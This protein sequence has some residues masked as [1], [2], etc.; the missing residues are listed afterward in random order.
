MIFQGSS[1]ATLGTEVKGSSEE[2]TVFMNVPHR[3][4]V[5]V[6]RKDITEILNRHMHSISQQKQYTQTQT[7]F[8]QTCL[9]MLR[10]K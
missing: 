9:N 6:Q 7:A 5:L 10:I 4:N 3:I 8:N 1:R 2:M